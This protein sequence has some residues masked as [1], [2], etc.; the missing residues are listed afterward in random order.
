MTRL[1]NHFKHRL[2]KKKQEEE[3]RLKAMEVETLANTHIDDVQTDDE[4]DMDT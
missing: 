1:T 3:K 2:F 4:N